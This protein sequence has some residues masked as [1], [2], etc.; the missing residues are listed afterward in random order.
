MLANYTTNRC[1][2]SW[3]KNFHSRLRVSPDIPPRSPT[4][5]FTVF[6]VLVLPSCSLAEVC[7]QLYHNVHL[8]LADLISLTIYPLPK[9]CFFNSMSCFDLHKL[10]FKTSLREYI[11][12]DRTVVLY[13]RNFVDMLR[14]EL[15]KCKLLCLFSPTPTLY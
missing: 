7:L 10:L 3:I 11:T 4:I 6:P 8:N 9:S 5:S 13:R 15:R 2:W 1:W 14:S 12:T